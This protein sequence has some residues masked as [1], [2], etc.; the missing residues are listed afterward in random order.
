LSK[1]PATDRRRPPH[2]PPAGVA[3][4][5]DHEPVLIG[6]HHRRSELF[7]DGVP[8]AAVA[9]AAGT[10]LYVYSAP[11]VRERVRGFAAAFASVPHALHYALKANS[12]LTLVRLMR[13]LGCLADANSIGEID[14]ALEA[15]FAPQE[16]VFTGVGKTPVELERAVGLGLRSINVESAGELARIDALARAHGRRARVALRINPDIDA[17]SHPHISTGL[18]VNK[19]GVPAADARAVC[20]DAA[21]RPGLALVGLHV[22]I[23][24]QMV[25]L[26]P[27]RRAAETLVGLARDLDADGIAIEHLDLGGGL[28]VAYDDGVAPSAADYAAAL[29]P[30]VEPAGRFLLLEPGRVLVAPAGALL[31]RVIDVKPQGEDRLFVVIDAGMTELMRPALYGAFHR[32]VPVSRADRPEALC[33]LVGPL[34]ETSDTLG[35][36]RRL[37]RPEVGDLF[38]VLDTGAY[39]FVMASNYNR[40]P[41]PAEALVD[42]DEWRVVRRRQTYD[43]MLAPERAR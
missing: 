6:F 28:G 20:R 14:V 40:R 30:I 25:S 5:A 11:T 22:H 21:R 9:A 23:G 29:L 24:S 42:G 19:F 12:N 4:T 15:G 3:P 16:I 39:G 43:E 35:R 36:D 8:L 41:L 17:L 31:T 13:E 38:A 27:I 18:R 37:P 10:P 7:C 32:I 33:D 2:D 26:D 34:C 1:L